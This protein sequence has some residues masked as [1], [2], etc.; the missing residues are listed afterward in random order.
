MWDIFFFNFFFFFTVL[1]HHRCEDF[2]LVPM[3]TGFS[4][5]WFSCC[6]AWALGQMDFSS[7]S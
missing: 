5:Q 4:L 3:S 2:S 1:G 7:C 6:G